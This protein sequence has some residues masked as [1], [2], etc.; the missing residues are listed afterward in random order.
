VVNLHSHDVERRYASSDDKVLLLT[1]H[2]AAIAKAIQLVKETSDEGGLEL[3][4]CIPGTGFLSQGTTG[5]ELDTEKKLNTWIKKVVRPLFTT[6]VDD[7]TLEFFDG[8]KKMVLH[9]EA[10]LPDDATSI[11]LGTFGH[12]YE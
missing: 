9:M 1:T 10:V 3:C 2:K 12:S 4:T 6:N 5:K 8:C 7:A 11:D